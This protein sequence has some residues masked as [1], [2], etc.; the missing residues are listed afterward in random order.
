MSDKIS[1]LKNS[2]HAVSDE[3]GSIS[4][5]MTRMRLMIGRRVIGRMAITRLTQVLELS[6]IDVLD[7]VNRCEGDATVGTIAEIMRLDP[8]R[9][10]RVVT[11]MVGKGLLKRA[12][13][14]K[15]GRQSVIGITPLGHSVLNEMHMAKI[16]VIHDV[17]SDWPKED[18]ITFA[19]LFDRFIGRFEKRIAPDATSGNDAAKAQ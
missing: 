17:V 9:G 5:T 4:Q 7:I 11:E 19:A 12:A 3:V 2:T 14:Q 10:S 13:S 15:D 6:H 8:S 1:S 16:G 18:V